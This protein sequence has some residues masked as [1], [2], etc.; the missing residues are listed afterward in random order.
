MVVI[1]L[2]FVLFISICGLL[3]NVWL[4]YKQNQEFQQTFEQQKNDI[5]VF[6]GYLY[7]I[8]GEM[9]EFTKTFQTCLLGPYMYTAEEQLQDYKSAVDMIGKN[10]ITIKDVYYA[11]SGIHCVVIG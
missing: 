5:A 8:N 6:T 7:L 3:Y 4:A 2:S 1:F 11:T 10:G 9:I